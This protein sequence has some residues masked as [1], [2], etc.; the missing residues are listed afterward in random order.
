[1]VIPKATL[2]EADSKQN[3]SQLPPCY[4]VTGQTQWVD[5]LSIQAMLVSEHTGCPSENICWLVHE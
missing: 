3:I 2:K 5:M 1:M 4:L